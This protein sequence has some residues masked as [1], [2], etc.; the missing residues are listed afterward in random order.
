MTG[1]GRP[2]GRRRSRNEWQALLAKIRGSGL[3]I[4]AFCQSEGI[5]EASYYRWRSRLADEVDRGEVCV[6][7]SAPAFVD[8]GTLNSASAPRQRL[9]L[10]LDLGDGLMLHLVRS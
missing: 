3:G 10:K 4:E 9:D 1:S 5:S 6:R 7:A 2:I 8:L